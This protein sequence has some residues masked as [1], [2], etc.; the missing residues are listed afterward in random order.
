MPSMLGGHLWTLTPFL[1]RPLSPPRPPPAQ[2]FAVPVHDPVRGPI[3]LT[4][5]LRARPTD[6]SL[7]IAVHGLGGSA[8]SPY[9]LAAAQAAEEAGMA[10]LR[11]NLRGADRRGDDFFHAG[12]TLDLHA[13]LA[14]PALATFERVYLIGYSL[15]GHIALRYAAEDHDPRVRAVTAICPPIDLARGARAIDHPRR[16][17]YRNKLLRNLKDVY[18]D[19]AVRG[20]ELPLAVD[21]AMR[22]DRIWTWDDLVVAPRW[23]F[24]DAA[25]YYD[26]TSVARVLDRLAVPALVVLATADPMVL[27]DTVRPHLDQHEHISTLW[28]DRGGHVGFPRDL[29]LGL[30]GPPGLE[31]QVVRWLSKGAC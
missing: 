30:G 23:G 5:R 10:S 13:V 22:I 1:L 6:T 3:R 19:V 14:S 24:R 2:H 21:D 8:A 7:V 31:R 11:L 18:R 17:L 4:G 25:D 26:R 20:H 15:G 28:V 9:L 16:A 27:A 12:L 29:D